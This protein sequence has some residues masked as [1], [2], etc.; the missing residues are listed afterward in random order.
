MYKENNNNNNNNNN[1]DK[2]RE[3][4]LFNQ[5]KVTAGNINDWN[6]NY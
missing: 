3:I 4:F 6:S 2:N 5:H 1:N